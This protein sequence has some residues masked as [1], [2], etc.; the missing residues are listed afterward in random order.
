M[1][2]GAGQGDR[3]GTVTPVILSWFYRVSDYLRHV[4]RRRVWAA[5]QATGR[6]GEDL[7]HR[8]LRGAGFTVVARNFRARSGAGEFDLVAWE[9][10][11]LVFVEVKSRFTD[12]FG[13]PERAIDD[14]KRRHLLRAAREYSRRTDVPWER[15]RFDMVGVLFTSPPTITH[16]RDIMSPRVAL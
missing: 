7:A 15:V 3:V 16:L 2:R 11:T 13:S 14:A 5:D 8:Y 9:G 4:A 10:E 6:R 1:L 12:E